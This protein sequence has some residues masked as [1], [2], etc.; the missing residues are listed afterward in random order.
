MQ[1]VPGKACK[2]FKRSWPKDGRIL[3]REVVPVWGERKVEDIKK[4]DVTLLLQKIV[5]RGSPSMSNSTFR[6]IRKMFNFSVERDISEY[7]PCMGVKELAP[8]PTRERAL[9]ESEINTLWQTLGNAAMSPGTKLAVK[10]ILVTAQRP[11]E[12]AGLHTSEIDGNIWT[13][14]KERAKN[15]K[16]HR[17]YLTALCVL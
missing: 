17:V 4:R 11:G 8:N 16:G 13:I 5:D 15:G 3:N 9:N 12:V 2:K 14:P 7:S 6:V 10:L 1:R